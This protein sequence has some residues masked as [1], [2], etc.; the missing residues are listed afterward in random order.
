[1]FLPLNGTIGCVQIPS[2]FGDLYPELVLLPEARRSD[3]KQNKRILRE[4]GSPEKVTKPDRWR[5]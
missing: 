2:S 3:P 5:I 1:M 4:T